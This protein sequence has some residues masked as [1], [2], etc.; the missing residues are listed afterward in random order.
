MECSIHEHFNF[1]TIYQKFEI[2][3]L[4]ALNDIIYGNYLC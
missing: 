1:F 4:N 2:N 3:F